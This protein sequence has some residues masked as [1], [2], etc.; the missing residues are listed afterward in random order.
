MKYIV[1]TC[2]DRQHM[3]D[4]LHS[5]IPNLI[6][7][8]DNN[9]DPVGNMLK[10]FKVAGDDGAIHIEDDAI[11]TDG[12]IEKANAVINNHPNIICQFFSMRKADLEIG[13]RIESG[14]NFTATVCFYTPPQMSKDL[15]SYF[16]TWSRWEEHPTGYDLTIA[17]Y[18]K[19]NKLTYYIHCPNLSDHRISKSII[20]P[21]RSSK[22]I[23]KSF[24]QS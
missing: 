2:P 10:S 1:R 8:F 16:P 20:G 13:S 24:K 6:E 9:K 17:D 19:K 15:I 7:C 23:S 5:K 12:F 22:R 21:R 11:L 4:Y 3:T 14:A 18:L